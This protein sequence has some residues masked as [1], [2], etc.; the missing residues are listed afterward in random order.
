MATKASRAAL[1]LTWV[2]TNIL[3]NI[4][5]RITPAL[6][7]TAVTDLYDTLM[8]EYQTVADITTLNALVL[9]TNFKENDFVFISD[10]GKGDTVGCYQ[11]IKNQSDVYTWLKKFELG[12]KTKLVESTQATLALYIS[13]DYTNGDLDIGYFVKLTN[14]YLYLVKAQNGSYIGDI[15]TDYELIYNGGI[16]QYHEVA[17]IAARTALTINVDFV[18]G[19]KCK[20]TDDGYG[21][22]DISEY[23]YNT[24]SSSYAWNVI[25]KYVNVE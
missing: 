10:I 8:S 22:V 4:L 24:D 5:K 6:M 7:R 23:S 12:N 20:V 9:G 13:T 17:T 25:G 3:D 18:I 11:Y 16:G 14:G 1:I 21:Y 19:D 2:N 15:S